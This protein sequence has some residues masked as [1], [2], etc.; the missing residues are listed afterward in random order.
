MSGR[1][2]GK[3]SAARPAAGDALNLIHTNNSPKPASMRVSASLENQNGLSFWQI[4]QALEVLHGPI[5]FLIQQRRCDE[6]KST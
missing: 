2:A 4:R 3:R 1:T 6:P 5:G